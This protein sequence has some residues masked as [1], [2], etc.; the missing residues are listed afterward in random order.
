MHVFGCLVPS[1]NMS[2]MVY[3]DV[4]TIKGLT[5]TVALKHRA[6]FFIW[7]LPLLLGSLFSTLNS[8]SGPQNRAPKFILT[9]N[10]TWDPVVND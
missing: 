2:R 8:N 9:E 4:R 3:L 5:F 10:D 7:T 6:L 1:S